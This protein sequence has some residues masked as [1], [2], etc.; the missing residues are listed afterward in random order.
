M[1][2]FSLVLALCAMLA[3]CS[4]AAIADDLNPPPWQRYT[5]GTTYAEWEFS[6][7]NPNANPDQYYNPFGM[8]VAQCEPGVGQSWLSNWGGRQGMWPLSGTIA[9]PILNYP[10]ANPYKDI[11]VQITWAQ[12]TTTSQPYVS[13]LTTGDQG[14]LISQQIIGQTGEPVGDGNWYSSTFEIQMSPNPS[15]ETVKID[16]T[17]VVDELI[18]DTD[19]VPEP[20]GL[21]TLLVSGIGLAGFAW[22]RRSQ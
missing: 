6:T 19:C 11:W 8:P 12:Q 16:G 1:K 5:P 3:I 15:T 10:I 7:S 14:K 2:T 9:V 18:I 4:A 21:L 22:R 13:E 17:I 20:S